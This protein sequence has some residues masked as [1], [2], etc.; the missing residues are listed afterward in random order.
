VAEIE[1][2][3]GIFEQALR[4]H[5]TRGDVGKNH[6]LEN[7]KAV[8]WWWLIPEESPLYYKSQLYIARGAHMLIPYFPTRGTE[9]EIF[10]NSGGNLVPGRSHRRD[11]FAELVYG[12]S[13]PGDRQ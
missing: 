3:A 2:D 1:S 13:R 11:K 9:R 8:G 7:I 5:L 4:L 12:E 6:F 10:R